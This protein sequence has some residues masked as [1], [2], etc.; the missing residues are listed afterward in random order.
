MP[1]A[2]GS[3]IAVV[4]A[5]LWLPAVGGVAAGGVIA[6]K[7]YVSNT[8]VNAV[9]IKVLPLIF[10]SQGGLASFKIDRSQSEELCNFSFLS[11]APLAEG[12]SLPSMEPHEPLEIDWEE[13]GVYVDEDASLQ[14]IDFE[15]EVEERNRQSSQ[16]V[17]TTP[18]TSRPVIFNAVNQVS[19]LPY[20]AIFIVGDVVVIGVVVYVVMAMRKGK[21]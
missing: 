11:V 16:V 5:P 20:L 7:A 18:I 21:S 3:A 9:D 17:L 10:G 1:I 4:T 8:T 2:A 15:A 12:A 14:E 13:N 6:A 19:S